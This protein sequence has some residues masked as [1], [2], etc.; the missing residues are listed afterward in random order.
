MEARE[1]DEKLAVLNGLAGNYAATLSPE[2][3]KM[4]LYLLK[5]YDV[6]VVQAAAL[7]M[8]RRCGSE[9]V[10]YRTMPPFALM[11]KELDRMT[12]ARN[13]ASG[14]RFT[15]PGRRVAPAC[16]ATLPVAHGRLPV[17]E[18]PAVGQLPAL[19]RVVVHK[20]FRP[21]AVAPLV[22]VRLH[23]LHGRPD[24]TAF[25]TRLTLPCRGDKGGIF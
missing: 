7:A 10:P 1:R 21:N 22:A 20:A 5:D 25:R 6:A 19:R 11:Q 23:L 8:I 4:W 12:G 14:R 15:P 24:K 2:T 9:T 18:R 17:P 13:H 16:I 3:A